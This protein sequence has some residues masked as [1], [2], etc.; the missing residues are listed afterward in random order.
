M[1][2]RATLIEISKLWLAL[3]LAVLT[4]IEAVSAT[5]PLVLT[6]SIYAPEQKASPVH[7]VGFRYKDDAIEIVLDNRSSKTVVG[8]EIVGTESA[9]S[10]CSPQVTQPSAETGGGA[11]QVKI[12]PHRTA[13]TLPINS[14]FSPPSLVRAARDSQTAYLQI[15]AGLVKVDFEDGSTWSP[16]T[17]IPMT[18]FDPSLVEAEAGTCSNANALAWLRH[19][20]KLQKLVLKPKLPVLRTL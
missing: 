1:K 13:V 12:P 2:A 17:E 3:T 5:A 19:W 15:Q 10:G 6:I 9:P 16:Y 11:G 4:C 20:P 8:V 14:P 18:P 7:I